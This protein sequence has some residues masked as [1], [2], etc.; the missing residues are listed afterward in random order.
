MR[1]RNETEALLALKN[2]AVGNA[3]S[4]AIA[5]GKRG[6]LSENLEEFV[7][8]LVGAHKAQAFG[9]PLARVGSELFRA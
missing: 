3:A 4:C 5:N 9:G 1:R 8:G 6:I 2:S 7:E